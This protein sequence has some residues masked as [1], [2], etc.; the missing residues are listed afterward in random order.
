MS[1]STEQLAYSQQKNRE[2]IWEDAKRQFEKNNGVK[3]C[4]WRDE[5]SECL[6]L[7][8]VSMCKK[9]NITPW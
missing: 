3:Y 7:I 4:S 6:N 1:L 9:A 5:D 8:Y 2:H